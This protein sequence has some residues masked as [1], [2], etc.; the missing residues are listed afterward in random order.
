M[1]ENKIKIKTER[2]VERMLGIKTERRSCNESNN[3]PEDNRPV[4][5][6]QQTRT[7]D[8]QPFINKIIALQTENQRIILDF[9]QKSAECEAMVIQ[10]QKMSERCSE[11]VF[12]L[13]AKVNTLQDELLSAKSDANKQNEND[14]KT[15]A[16]LTCENQTLKARIKQLQA[17]INQHSAFQMGNEQHFNESN[18]NVYEV[19]KLIDHKRKKD[20]MYFLIRWANF[21]SKDDTWERESNLMCFD[22]LNEYK[23]KMNLQFHY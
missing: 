7:Q 10:K 22:L 2:D 13:K 21:T 19:E 5:S 17:G 6:T 14:K 3:L 20:G 16:G 4:E 11:E 18:E 9:Q 8:K 1:I 23:Q 15:I 12:S